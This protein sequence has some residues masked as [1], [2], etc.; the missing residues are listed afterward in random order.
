MRIENAR[1]GHPS[2]EHGHLKPSAA[3]MRQPSLHG[4]IHGVFQMAVLFTI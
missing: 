1:H 2:E 4:C 3:G